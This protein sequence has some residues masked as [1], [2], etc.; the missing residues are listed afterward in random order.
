MSL[1]S[2][3]EGP[4]K[5]GSDRHDLQ[6]PSAKRKA[7]RRPRRPNPDLN[8]TEPRDPHESPGAG[9]RGGTHVAPGG[10]GRGLPA[11]QSQQDKQPLCPGHR[12]R[13]RPPRVPHLTLI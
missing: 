5:L 12:E 6:P 10:T 8:L 4:E 1:Y 7:P 9:L 3:E 13:E 2:P 11:G